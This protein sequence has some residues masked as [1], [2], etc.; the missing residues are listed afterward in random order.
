MNNN[1]FEHM[2]IAI[3][4]GGIYSATMGPYILTYKIAN[5]GTGLS[6][7]YQNGTVVLHKMK[8]FSKENNA[9]GVIL[10]TGTTSIIRLSNGT[11][12]LESYGK[13]YKLIPDSDL[14]LSNTSCKEKLVGEGR[15]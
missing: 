5:D 9:Y 11:Y 6:C 15:P 10:E 14:T 1:F 4:F 2:P 12:S 3:D 13:K 8:I 7:Y